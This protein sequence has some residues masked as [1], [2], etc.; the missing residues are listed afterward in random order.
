MLKILSFKPRFIPRR[1]RVSSL[2]SRE[3]F[4]TIIVLPWMPGC[5]VRRSNVSVDPFPDS[6]LFLLISTR[7]LHSTC[8][9]SI[10]LRHLTGIFAQPS[11]CKTA[12]LR[13][14]KRLIGDLNECYK[15]RASILA[16]Y[17]I[18]RPSLPRMDS[19]ESRHEAQIKLF[20]EPILKDI[21]RSHQIS[22]IKL[23]KTDSALDTQ[24]RRGEARGGK[25]Y[26]TSE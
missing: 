2:C 13:R 19:D 25:T 8:I 1:R 6:L 15:V 22:S 17:N 12:Y 20:G 5:L 9:I 11:G 3:L 16:L 23:H 10:F 24:E 26:P 21:R 4:Q 18:H 14:A 7:C